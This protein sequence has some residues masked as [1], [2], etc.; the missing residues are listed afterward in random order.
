MGRLRLVSVPEPDRRARRRR[1]R[2]ADHDRVRGCPDAVTAPLALHRVDTP[3]T[4]G[5]YA[6]LTMDYLSPYIPVLVLLLITGVLCLAIGVLAT[7]LGPP[8]I[9]GIKAPPVERRP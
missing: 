4:G 8:P 1:H 7:V 6:A 2:V 9:P 5:Y 3:P